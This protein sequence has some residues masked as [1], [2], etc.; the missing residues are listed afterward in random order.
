[1]VFKSPIHENN[2]L[3]VYEQP[4]KH[5]TYTLVADTAQGKGVDYSA[6]S[7]FDVSEMPY[8]QVAV[9]RDNQNFHLMLV[10]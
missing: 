3:T 9:Y 10:S 8:K 5:H 4:K 1:M 6:F 7:V 2:N